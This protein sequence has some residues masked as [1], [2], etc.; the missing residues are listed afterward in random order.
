[1]EVFEERLLVRTFGIFTGT[2]YWG[3]HLEICDYR[4]LGSIF[5]GFRGQANLEDIWRISKTGF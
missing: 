4:L 5:G 1:L 2:D 3:G